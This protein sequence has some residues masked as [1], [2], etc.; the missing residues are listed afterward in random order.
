M[1]LSD[2]CEKRS[3]RSHGQQTKGSFLEPPSHTLLQSLSLPTRW[4]LILISN[5]SLH[6]RAFLIHAF[7]LLNSKV[8][9][10][11][12][13]L[14]TSFP[15]NPPREPLPAAETQQQKFS[16]SEFI[17]LSEIA[18]FSILHVSRFC[19][20]YHSLPARCW[21][22]V[23]RSEGAAPW[24]QS[25]TTE[26]S[27]RNQIHQRQN[28]NFFFGLRGH[29]ETFFRSC[30]SEIF[31][32]LCVLLESHTLAVWKLCFFWG[33]RSV[34]GGRSV[35]FLAPNFFLR[36]D[37]CRLPLPAADYKYTTRPT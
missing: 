35:I 29:N 31:V 5:F 2:G 19:Y 30:V 22:L 23:S 4:S 25:E 17:N 32:K 36:W 15:V 1:L 14:G 27:I 11:A 26:R 37:R 13:S 16:T 3:K 33:A 9:L 7:L 28:A 24:R 12:R 8:N 34:W 20:F 21:R 6:P 10:S 18:R